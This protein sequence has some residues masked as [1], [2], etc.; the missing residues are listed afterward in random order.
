LLLA[1]NIN[2]LETSMLKLIAALHSQEKKDIFLELP[3]LELLMLP[4][5]A[6]KDNLKLMK[7]LKKLKHL[8]NLLSQDLKNL[9]V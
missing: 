8:K 6:Q 7:K 4:K 3:L 2:S 5:F 1:S 9:K